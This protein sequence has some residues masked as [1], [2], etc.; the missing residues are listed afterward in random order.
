LHAQISETP[1]SETKLPAIVVSDQNS[2]DLGTAESA[3][4][5]KIGAKALLERPIAR[6]G[7]VLESIPGVI[8]TQHSGGGKAN[9]YYLRGF[10]LDHGTDFAGYVNGVPINLPSHAH[11]QG[12]LDLNWVIPELVDNISYEKGVYYADQG[13]FA[14]AG[15][16]S[17]EYYQVLPQ[18]F[19]LLEIG[20]LGFDRALVAYWFHSKPSMTTELGKLKKIT[21]N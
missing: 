18:D 10:N 11:G 8:I 20:G 5:G 21:A 7:E 15:S 14:N 17:I 3:S 2:D 13:D 6:A 9:Q 12:Y 1:V 4:E 16:A 19:A